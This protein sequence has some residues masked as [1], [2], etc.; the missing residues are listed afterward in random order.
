MSKTCKYSAKYF[1]EI[2]QEARVQLEE[3]KGINE[4][5]MQKNRSKRREA[6]MAIKVIQK[7]QETVYTVIMTFIFH[8][9]I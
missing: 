8:N 3:D 6:K 7:S 9:D 4:H 1:M 5:L 2:S